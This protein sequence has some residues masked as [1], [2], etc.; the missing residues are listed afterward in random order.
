MTS[1]WMQVGGTVLF[2][3]A[4]SAL[5]A[6][7]A[8]AQLAGV[9]VTLV[10]GP[11]S[12]GCFEPDPEEI[13]VDAVATVFYGAGLAYPTAWLGDSS[14]FGANAPAI[15]WGDGSTVPPL[16][17]TGIPFDTTSTPPGA[18]GPVRAYR[19]SFSHTYTSLDPALIR[20]ASNAQNFLT[21]Y[22]F[23]GN[24]A[25][26]QTPTYS[27]FGGTRMI[28]TNS[29]EFVVAIPI[30]EEIDTVSDIGLMLLALAIGAAGLALLRR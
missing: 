4:T 16:F 20:V 19:G 24:S 26:V 28:L 27:V 18:P 10:G 30:C 3:V 29:T 9:R 22:A 12:L 8:S 2:F 11:P 23:T 13:T 7:P 1:R 17:P 14:G 25:T 5:W 6:A 21:G 15:D